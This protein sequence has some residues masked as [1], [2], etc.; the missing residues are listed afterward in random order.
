MYSERWQI[1]VILVESIE[2]ILYSTSQIV[3]CHP[4]DW[5]KRL[6]DVTSQGALAVAVTPNSEA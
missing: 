5:H 6:V 3:A 2:D 1:V 4:A